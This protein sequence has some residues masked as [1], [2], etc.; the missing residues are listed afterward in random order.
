MECQPTGSE[1]AARSTPVRA[2]ARVGTLDSDDA[3]AASFELLDAAYASLTDAIA[4]VLHNK[5]VVY[6]SLNETRSLL[7]WGQ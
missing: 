4:E 3:R 2:A 1:L 7:E 5:F 6:A